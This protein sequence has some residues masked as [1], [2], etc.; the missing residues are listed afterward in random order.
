M[1]ILHLQTQYTFGL[2][3]M[4]KTILVHLIVR[5]FTPVTDLLLS[6]A[7]EADSDGLKYQREHK[8]IQI[9]YWFSSNV[10]TRKV[11]YYM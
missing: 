6:I 8:H 5:I 3:K 2:C 10:E 4:G 11:E 1:F 9:T 7:M